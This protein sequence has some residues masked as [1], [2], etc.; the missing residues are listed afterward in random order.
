MRPGVRARAP[1]RRAWRAVRWYLRETSGETAYEK[2]LVRHAR[3]HPGRAPVPERDFW[4]ARADRAAGRPHA[5][6][7]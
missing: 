4:R 6:C 7:C 3:A 2:Y 5:G 1:W